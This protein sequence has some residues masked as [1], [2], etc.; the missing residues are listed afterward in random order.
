MPKTPRPYAVECDWESSPSQYAHGAPLLAGGLLQAAWRDATFLNSPDTNSFK[1]R[2]IVV[3]SHRYALGAGSVTFAAACDP[4]GTK[5]NLELMEDATN[6]RYAGKCR[7]P[8]CHQIFAR[9]A[10]LKNSVEHIRSYY[11][12]KVHGG[13]RVY[14]GGRPGVIVGFT[15]QYIEV[16]LDSEERPITCHATSDMTYPLE[17]HVGPGPDERFAHLV[18]VGSGAVPTRA[19]RTT[20]Q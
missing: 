4:V 11:G 1:R 12:L 14:H 2:H 13:M 20:E 9:A 19:D 3:A 5:A 16:L 6:V 15:S 17:A 7:R 10:S 8:G 18:K